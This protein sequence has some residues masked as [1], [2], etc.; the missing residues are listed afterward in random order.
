[1]GEQ[2]FTMNS[3]VVGHLWCDDLVQDVHQQFCE[4][5]RRFTISEFPQISRILLHEISTVRLGSHKFSARCVPYR[6]MAASKTKRTLTF[7]NHIIWVTTGDETWV[8]FVNVEAKEQS[9]QWMHTHSPN[10][11][12]E[13]KQLLSACQKA[14]GNCFLGQERSAD[15]EIH[16]T[17]DHTNVTSV[18]RNTKK[19]AYG[20]SKQKMWNAD[21]RYSAPP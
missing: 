4:R 8:S 11:P 18:L 21:I 20:H 17:G 1:M 12:T 14:D 3:E 10:K 5:R 13:F 7:L 2:M 19:T 6:L 16:A 15:G 9:K